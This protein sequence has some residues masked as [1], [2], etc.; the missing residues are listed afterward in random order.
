MTNRFTFGTS[1]GSTDQ[2]RA[3]GGVR[4]SAATAHAH[5]EPEGIHFV[6]ERAAL[7]RVGH[8]PHRSGVGSERDAASVGCAEG[9]RRSG[10]ATVARATTSSSQAGTRSAAT[11]RE[12]R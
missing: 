11:A 7:H 9:N 3:V 4:R 12:G 2:D 10:A 1:G 6:A 5:A 8:E